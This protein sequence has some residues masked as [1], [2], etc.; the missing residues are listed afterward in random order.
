MQS[1]ETTK[2]QK[3]V[4]VEEVA[5]K[6]IDFFLNAVINLDVNLKV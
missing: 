2:L 6:L 3:M 1:S 4:H 5:L